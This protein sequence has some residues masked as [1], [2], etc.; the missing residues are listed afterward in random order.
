MLL[1]RLVPTVGMHENSWLEIQSSSVSFGLFKLKMFQVLHWNPLLFVFRS[2]C[3][4]VV[5]NSRWIYLVK[6]EMPAYNIL[7]G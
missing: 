7:Q 3:A 4:E 5:S 6:P 1:Y 2:I